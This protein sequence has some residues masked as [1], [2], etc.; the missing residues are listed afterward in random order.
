MTERKKLKAKAQRATGHQQRVPSRLRAHDGVSGA[1]SRKLGQQGRTRPRKR[2]SRRVSPT[3]LSNAFP[4][5][6]KCSKALVVV[7]V[8]GQAIDG[9]EDVAETALLGL[10]N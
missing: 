2:T 9:V 6:W 3:A 7:V 1:T 8:V 10:I 4:P 5:W